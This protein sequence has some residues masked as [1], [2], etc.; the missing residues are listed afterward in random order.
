MAEIKATIRLHA[1]QVK[2]AEEF[3]LTPPLCVLCD[4]Y[5]GLFYEVQEKCHDLV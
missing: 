1:E 5:H 2:G 4:K 3:Q